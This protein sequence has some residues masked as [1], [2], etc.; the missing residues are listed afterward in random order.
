[1][2]LFEVE[3]MPFTCWVLHFSLSLRCLHFPLSHSLFDPSSQKLPGKGCP[4]QGA[5]RWAGEG[6]L[7]L[8]ARAVCGEVVLLREC[9]FFSFATAD[10][11]PSSLVSVWSRLWALAGAD[12]SCSVVRDCSG[13]LA[14]PPA[15]GGSASR[16]ARVGR[17]TDHSFGCCGQHLAAQ[18]KG[19]DEDGF[20]GSHWPL[21]RSRGGTARHQSPV[22]LLRGQQHPGEMQDG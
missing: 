17:L 19:V 2:I 14:S 10:S 16:V 13:L 7:L 15:H 5:R 4:G 21:C 3:G 11:T 9:T 22:Y 18:F 1:M 6:A 8:L 20:W 12:K